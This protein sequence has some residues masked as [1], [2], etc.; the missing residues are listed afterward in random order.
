MLIIKLTNLQTIHPEF[1]SA[2]PVAIKK[3]RRRHQRQVSE[4][5]HLLKTGSKQKKSANGCWLLT[6]DAYWPSEVLL[7][8]HLQRWPNIKP[9]L[10]QWLVF[11]M[12]NM[13]PTEWF[14]FLRP[15]RELQTLRCKIM[16]F[17]NA[18]TRL[19][20]RKPVMTNHTPSRRGCKLPWIGHV[21]AQCCQGFSASPTQLI[22]TPTFF[23]YF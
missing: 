10:G 23:F 20:A 1:T 17:K 2:D 6:S 11:C 5:A 12:V 3:C 4:R 13:P 21:L 16:S 14:P 15:G 7:G 22:S 19:E 18:D 8:Q 9:A